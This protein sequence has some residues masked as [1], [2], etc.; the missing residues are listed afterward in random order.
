M[1]DPAAGLDP[2]RILDLG[3][4]RTTRDRAELLDAL[5]DATAPLVFVGPDAAV[6]LTSPAA[7]EL[8]GRCLEGCDA[9]SLVGAEHAD[10]LRRAVADGTAFRTV[11]ATGPEGALTVEIRGDAPPTGTTAPVRCLVIADV[12]TELKGLA[13]L[14][15]AHQRS[16]AL[17][18]AMPDL[19]FRISSDLTFRDYRDPTARGLGVTPEQFLGK[20]LQD[21]LPAEVVEQVEPNLI[22]ALTTDRTV[23]YPSYYD[24]AD[25]RHTFD[26]RVVKSGPDEVVLICRDT[27]EQTRAE[28]ELRRNQ[29][30]LQRIVEYSREYT[31]I[32]D[33]EH[34]ILFVSAPVERILGYQPDEL[35]GSNALDLIHPDDRARSTRASV[36]VTKGAIP[37]RA[38]RLRLRNKSG[39]WR[40]I[41]ST[42]RPLFGDELI[43][44]LLTHCRDITDYAEVEDTLRD[45]LG[46]LNAIVETAADGIITI[47]PRGTIESINS[48]AQKMFRS[49][50]G[51][52]LG[53]AFED[54]LA[55]RYRAVLAEALRAIET[56]SPSAIASLPE[57]LEARREDGTTFPVTLSSSVVPLDNGVIITII[58]RDVSEKRAMERQLEFQATHDALTGLPN[59]YLFMAALEQA[60]REVRSNSHLGA[61]LFLDLDRFKVVNDSL[62]HASG[63]K[64]LCA[65]ASRLNAATRGRGTVARFGGDEFLILCP[66]CEDAREA[67]I[68][69]ADVLQALIPPFRIDDEEVFV[70]GSAGIAVMAPGD[71]P[72]DPDSVIRNADVALYRAKA[73]GRSRFERYDAGADRRTRD[74]LSLETSLR[75]A[76]EREELI[77]YFQPILSTETGTFSGTEALIRWR[78]DG[79]LIPPV[80][81][82]S[83][84]E[85]TGIIT[86]IGAWILRDACA[87]TMRWHERPELADLTVSVNASGIQ[88][89]RTNLAA[90]VASVLCSTGLAPEHLVVE[91][92]ESMLLHDDDATLTK[93]RQLKETGI[94]LAIDDF[95]TGYSSLAYLRKL[96]VDIIKV[97]R[98]FINQIDLDAH[99]VEIVRTITSLAHT[100]G[101]TVVAEGVETVAQYEKLEE[102]GCD[103][104]QGFLFAK[105]AS[106][107][108]ALATL[109]DR[110]RPPREV[111]R[112]LHV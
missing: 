13:D 48:A 10:A 58:V 38:L 93:L 104:I 76:L 99:T 87:T 42:A 5:T 8:L 88:L 39:G 25:G 15:A 59:R 35:L 45:S 11:V 16:L 108:E 111:Y 74:L 79:E 68:L 109:L 34:R 70:T 33:R 31:T 77:T 72:P 46:R 95:G 6:I 55:P 18:E 40:V 85:E 14:E 64:L 107:D 24:Y 62:G 9:A 90:E 4:H 61:V 56:G 50:S 71:G 12:T 17:L 110:I 52:L 43:G 63:D 19:L 22:E 75:H 54:L 41:E 86:E 80:R 28:E 47:N 29:A 44:G 66:R 60:L 26:N 7:D 96:P 57:D 27:T 103:H 97:D 91:I 106:D 49:R 78:H 53:T 98:S 21:F 83:L 3:K 81:F 73:R 82:I 23:T 37:L 1:Y 84:A 65:V 51:S 2:S 36:A 94:R 102:L 69:A 32:T 20:H 89:Y 105:P 30:R 92:T 101:M 67:E 100:L 112:R